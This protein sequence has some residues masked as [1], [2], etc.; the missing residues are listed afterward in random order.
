MTVA[1]LASFFRSHLAQVIVPL[2]VT[3]FPS[4]ALTPEARANTTARASRMVHGFR[5]AD[6]P[7]APTRLLN[8]APVSDGPILPI[9]HPEYTTTF[10]PTQWRTCRPFQIPRSAETLGV[11]LPA[12]RSRGRGSR[13]DGFLGRLIRAGRGC[14]RSYSRGSGRLPG[15]CSSGR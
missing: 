10:R 5:M 1:H 11:A 2:R 8:R 6:P 4:S 7:L 15:R 13:A 12:N 9:I 3:S 14:E